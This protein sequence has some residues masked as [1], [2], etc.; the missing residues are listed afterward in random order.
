[1][2][3]SSPDKEI[4]DAN[5]SHISVNPVIDEIFVKLNEYSDILDSVGTFYGKGHRELINKLKEEISGGIA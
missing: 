5:S 2:A 4:A 3:I 1:M